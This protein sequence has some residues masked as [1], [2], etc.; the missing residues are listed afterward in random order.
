MNTALR[1][2]SELSSIDTSLLLAGILYDKQYFNGTNADETSIRTM[3]SEIFNR[4]NWNF[5]SNGTNA[6]AMAWY[7][8]TGFSG[9]YWVGYCEG[10]IIYCLGLGTS[11]TP[12]PASC[13]NYW[14]SGYIW[15]TNYG[16][17]YVYFPPL[18]TYEYSHCWIDFRHIADSYMNSHSSTYFENSRRAALAQ[19]TYCS[20]GPD[21]AIDVGYSSNVWGLTA[22]DDPNGYASHGIPPDGF[23]DGTIAPTAAGGSIVFTPEYSEPTLNYFYTHY[24]P[25]IWTAY[26][27]RDA[28][29]LGKGWYDVDELG[30]DQGPIVIMIE[31]YRNQRPWQLFMQNQE[32]QTGLQRAGFVALPFV[33]VAAEAQPDQNTVTLAWQAQTGRTYQVEYSPDLQS[34]F[35]SPTGEVVAAGPTASWTDSGPPATPSMP[36]SANARFYRVFE[37]GSP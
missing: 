5:M 10:M 31:N 21:P 12:L 34:W 19:V 30:I 9:S 28:F 32:V 27:F 35:S 4:V 18:F 8:N 23:D 14:T 29:N 7:P 26:G 13:W 24:R 11:T 2:N 15:T 37:F 3:A 6:V 33:N 16:Q 36:F 1:A 20:S 25:H 17:S 22:S